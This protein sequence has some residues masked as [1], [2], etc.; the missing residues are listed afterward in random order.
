MLF[1]SG[2]G[3]SHH[4]RARRSAVL[5]LLAVLEIPLVHFSVRLWNTL[6]QEASVAGR[7]TD[8]TM[9]GLMLFSLFLGVVV[10]TMMYVWLL[11]HRQRA[12][13]LQDMLDDSGLD[14]AL[15][16]RRAEATS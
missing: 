4:Q 6:H 16:A 10:F 1:R 15:A 9:D 14:A 5:A 2:L 13:A 11:L 12:L 3:G 7:G 8:V